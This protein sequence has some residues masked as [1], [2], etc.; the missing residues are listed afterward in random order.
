MTLSRRRRRGHFIRQID[1]L[2]PQSGPSYPASHWHRPKTHC[3]RPLHPWGQFWVNSWDTRTT[4][5]TSWASMSSLYKDRNQWPCSRKWLTDRVTVGWK[6]LEKIVSQG[7]RI[8]KKKSRQKNKNKKNSWNQINKK[9]AIIIEIA[10]NG[11][12]PKKLFLKLI[13]LISQVFW[14][15]LF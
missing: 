14:P 2:C 3:P 1:L 6:K 8:F 9:L 13:Y 5:E 7:A 4:K 15:G 12:W 10:K 11:I